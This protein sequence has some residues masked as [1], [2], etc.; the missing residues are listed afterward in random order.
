MVATNEARK[1]TDK[2]HAKE[3]RNFTIKNQN[4]FYVAKAT[5]YIKSTA[6]LMRI[7]YLLYIPRSRSPNILTTLLRGYKLEAI[8]MIDH[9]ERAKLTYRLSFYPL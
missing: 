6:P 4:Y 5:I 9:I 3:R 2:L 8:C 7:L 1:Y